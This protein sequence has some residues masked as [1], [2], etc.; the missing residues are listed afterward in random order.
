MRELLKDGLIKSTNETVFLSHPNGTMSL[1]GKAMSKGVRGKYCDLLD[2]HGFTDN[3]SEIT[4]TPDS[5]TIF[6]DWKNGQHT[7][8]V[9]YGSFETEQTS[10]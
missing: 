9:T 4:I 7:T 2:S 6:T 5:L 8:R 10:H 1:N 3:H